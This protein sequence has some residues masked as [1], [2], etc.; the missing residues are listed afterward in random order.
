VVLPISI[1]KRCSKACFYTFAAFAVLSAVIMSLLRAS[2]PYLNQYHSEVIDWLVAEQNITVD[3][4]SIDAGWYRFGPALIINTLD[5]KF[6][7]EQPYDFDVRSIKVKVDFWNSI[8]ERKLLIDK[9]ILDGVDINIPYNP[10]I[11]DTH[12]ANSSQNTN[13]PAVSSNQLFD[14][15]L[16][17]FSDFE[18]TNSKVRIINPAGDEKVIHL[19]EF[20]WQNDGRR[21]RGEGLAS[22][23]NGNAE[24]YAK[25]IVDLKNSKSSLLEMTGQIYLQ[26]ENLNLSSWFERVLLKRKGIKNGIVSFESWIEIKHNQVDNVLLQLK[27]SSFS[28]QLDQQQQSFDIENGQLQW[29]NTALGWQLDSYDLSFATNGKDWP[30]LS[31]QIRNENNVLL[32]AANQVELAYLA[33]FVALSKHID[34]DVFNN[35]AALRPRGTLNNIKVKIP[36][37]N[38]LKLQYQLQVDSLALNAWQGIPA[39][40]NIDFAITGLLDKGV[41]TLNIADTE[42]DVRQYFPHQWQVNRLT[43]AFS[44]S[45]YGDGE[46]KARGIEIIADSLLLETPE[47]SVDS[48]V[49]LDIPAEGNSFLSLSG[50]VDLH[51]ASKAY[52]FYPTNYMGKDLIAYLQSGLQAGTAKNAQLLWFGE[53]AQYPYDKGDGIFQAK[54]KM[55]NGQFSFDPE[56]PPLTDLKLNLLFENDDLW[57]GPGKGNLGDVAVQRVTGNLLNLGDAGAVVIDAQFATDGKSAIE[58]INQSPLTPLKNTFV[59]TQIRD[60]LTGSLH[61]KIPLTGKAVSLSGAINLTDNTVYLKPLGLTLEHVKSTVEFTESIVRSPR[62]QAQLWGQPVIA[63]LDIGEKDS[64]FN[65]DIGLQGRWDSTDVL[66]LF[67]PILAD[68]ILGKFDWHGKVNVVI[69]ADDKLIYNATVT[70]AFDG[71]TAELPVPFSKLKD[72]IW[73][74]KVTLNGSVSQSS[75]TVNVRD[76][77]QFKTT[78]VH[79]ND[80]V[81]VLNS[82]VNIGDVKQTQTKPTQIKSGENNINITLDTLDIASWSDW[83]DGLN[84]KHLNDLQSEEVDILPTQ[85]RVMIKQIE[86]QQ[87]KINDLDISGTAKGN[88]LDLVVQANEF[89]ST[90]KLAESQ[91]ARVRFEYLYLPDLQFPEEP[92]AP[93]SLSENTA[94]EVVDDAETID[95]LQVPSF[96]LSCGVCIINK[97]DLGKVEVAIT[98]TGK[99]LQFDKL[100]VDMLHTQF[101][102]SGLWQLN[103]QGEPETKLT[104]KMKTESVE[105]LATNLGQ[106]SPLVK[107]P[108]DVQFDFVWDAD[109]TDLSPA[110]M[111]GY[112]M[113]EG[114]E[115]RVSSVS[116]K[117]TRFLSI[118]SLQS[119]VKKL[120]L[121][122]SDVFNN[123]LAYDSLSGSAYIINGVATNDDLVINSSSGRITGSGS[124]YWVSEEIDY[125]FNFYPDITSSLPVLTAFAVTPIT[126]IAVFALSKILEPVVDVIT[127]LRFKVSGNLNDLQFTEVERSQSEI[128]VP[129]KL[130]E[131]SRK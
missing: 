42:I 113:L 73:P 31:L 82:Q 65:I 33:P 18:L 91:P 128:K 1:F 34:D 28:W 59:D 66:P 75:L 117:G 35:I 105:Q 90:L 64:D 85:V 52:Y 50:S 122:F 99:T 97:L 57:L 10:F 100:N 58:L 2:L 95:W 70:T 46:N 39:V 12:N 48:Q 111:S 15:F 36:L 109:I 41:G 129:P 38:W 106:E 61:L 29:R 55:H 44:W 6:T 27:P 53:F 45:M 60:A 115:G 89:Y 74:T 92:N 13:S 107:T 72:D 21:H 98:N 51:D 20:R 93:T 112:V 79:D 4:E 37:D 118:L 3:V 81:S 22:V 69:D 62:L 56:W 32:L 9:L 7:D 104:G 114:K 11:A 96:E 78:F 68:Q 77:I 101:N 127:E 121:D 88:D 76:D 110:T 116:D 86:F 30:E 14:I 24:N 63:S 125:T 43:S 131:G 16:L 84:R 103:S 108:M 130:F 49:L 47:V 25:I 23:S 71:V 54:V 67:V 80:L 8:L 40:S 126:A 123:E 5:V 102:A 124:L 17:H 19:Q 87:Q 26:A 119:L 94:I 83:Y 120:S